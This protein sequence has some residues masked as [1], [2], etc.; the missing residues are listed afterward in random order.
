MIKNTKKR[1]SFC[2][3]FFLFIALTLSMF[4]AMPVASAEN[5]DIF[6]VQIGEGVEYDG[7]IFKIVDNVQF[8][9]PAGSD[10]YTLGDL[11]DIGIYMAPSIAEIQTYVSPA[12]IEYIEPNAYM[13]FEPIEIN[14]SSPN[15][16]VTT[17][18]TYPVNDPR[19]SLQWG[20]IETHAEAIYNANLNAAGVKIAIIDTGIYAGH[21]D[22]ENVNIGVGYN[23]MDG[24]TNVND[25]YGHGTSVAGVIA[26]ATNNA[27]GVASFASDAT[28]YPIKISG[29]NTF[30]INNLVAGIYKVIDDFDCDVINI[31][32]S[33]SG[34]WSLQQVCQLAADAGIIVVSTS[35]NQPEDLTAIRYPAGYD[36]VI[37]V[38]AVG[39]PDAN[40][41]WTRLNYVYNE[42]V[43]ITAPGVGIQLIGTDHTSDY[44]SDNGTS[45]AAPFISALAAI[46]KSYDSS[47]GLDEFRELLQHSVDDAG[48]P[49]YDVYYGHGV[50]DCEKFANNLT[51]PPLSVNPS[52]PKSKDVEDER[53][54][55]LRG[56][57]A[58]EKTHQVQIVDRFEN[59]VTC[60]N[61]SVVSGSSASHY[62]SLDAV[63]VTSGGLITVIRSGITAIQG[64]YNGE[65][66]TVTIIVPG[67]YNRSST[68][69]VADATLIAEVDAQI[70]ELDSRLFS[71]EL[72]DMNRSGTI[73]KS[74]STTVRSIDA[75]LA[76]I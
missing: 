74:D 35:G 25:T 43:F 38:G 5:D 9:A 61:W 8:S 64:T 41:N 1:F 51:N 57:W 48:T 12:D 28:I 19:Y 27:K 67:D 29:G 42:S 23:I 2:L 16:T 13:E 45:Y 59:P 14:T 7:F 34:H 69:S 62:F 26:A 4:S 40:G 53:V 44:F 72:A 15:N 31:S 33:T 71:L 75:E 3:A 70:R 76:Y 10:I 21:E 46:A 49:G 47:I 11:G 60:T 50:I 52:D 17:Y 36:T 24:T 54:L 65:T 32:A 58:N 63:S 20:M 73:T 56:T 68:I 22:F 30:S 66:V 37:G 18:A 39:A 55:I 6:D